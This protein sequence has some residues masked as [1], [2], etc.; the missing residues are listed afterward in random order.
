MSS[1]SWR[2]KLL[3]LSCALGVFSCVYLISVSPTTSSLPQQTATVNLEPASALSQPL[4]T[5]FGHTGVEL[6]D[7]VLESKMQT[8]QAVL[9]AVK[10]VL[11]AQYLPGYASPCWY[12]NYT[13]AK[14]EM[15]KGGTVSKSWTFTK[16]KGQLYC[17]PSFY[18]M[19]Y[20]KCGTTT[21][22]DLLSKH[23]LIG[24]NLQ[25]FK[26]KVDLDNIRTI[27]PR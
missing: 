6:T 15:V 4:S 18:L 20:A 11:P 2:K 7:P 5:T 22:C 10:S 16:D 3:I 24:T 25:W 1:C 9:D 26:T 14:V 17:L 12:A 13:T 19:G 21:V 27:V 23:S 8:L